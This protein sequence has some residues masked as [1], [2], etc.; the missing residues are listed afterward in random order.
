MFK[1]IWCQE[2]T[3][4]GDWVVLSLLPSFVWSSKFESCDSQLS[5][6]G[7]GVAALTICAGHINILWIR[8]GVEND[9][10]R[11]AE[12]VASVMSIVLPQQRWLN[13]IKSQAISGMNI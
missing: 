11:T 2:F 7:L 12:W 9:N 5:N 3:P 4:E 10:K 6:L 8:K 1:L 13:R